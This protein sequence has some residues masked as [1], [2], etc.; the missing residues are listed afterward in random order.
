MIKVY[1][2]RIHNLGDFAHCLPTLSGLYKATGVKLSLSICDRLQRFRGI[3]DLLLQQEMFGEVLFMHETIHNLTQYIVVD[4]TG[5]DGDYGDSPIVCH[6]YHNHIKSTYNGKYEID[7]DFELQ[8]PK[9][10]I[11]YHADKVIIGDRWSP[12]D[13]PDVDDR[14]K[15]NLL[16]NIIS[17]DKSLF[18]DYGNDLVYNCSLIKYNPN[19]FISTITGISVLS[20]LMKKDTYVLWDDDMR[21]WQGNPIEHVRD[22]H[23]YRNRLT[24]LM[25]IK[26]FKYD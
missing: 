7:D 21:I 16:T 1:S 5:A 11:N 9:L 24:K 3:K 13:A 17:T 6:R 19:P 8:V 12:S 15:S 20:D 18:L 23:Y 22:R 26:D 2:P 4:D 14:R 10:E 25:Y